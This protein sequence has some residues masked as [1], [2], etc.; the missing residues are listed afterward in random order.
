MADATPTDG[1]KVKDARLDDKAATVPALEAG[2]V[3]PVADEGLK[4]G[5]SSRQI[6]MIAIVS[7]SPSDFRSVPML[8]CFHVR[9]GL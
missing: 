2:F 3:E 4:R 6:S 7:L 1:H 9:E 8:I 5:L